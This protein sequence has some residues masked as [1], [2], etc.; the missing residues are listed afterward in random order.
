MAHAVDA[1]FPLERD[2]DVELAD[3][4]EQRV[5]ELGEAIASIAK[6]HDDADA[7]LQALAGSPRF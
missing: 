1:L 3:L 7:R 6:I 4:A 2:E 5:S